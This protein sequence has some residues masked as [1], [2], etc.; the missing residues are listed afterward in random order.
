MQ[1]AP[2]RE[3]AVTLD[4]LVDFAHQHVGPDLLDR[5]NAEF[6]CTEICGQSGAFVRGFSRKGL[7]CQAFD[8]RS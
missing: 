6:D 1:K 4:E 5:P 7:R 2:V 3:P 8:I